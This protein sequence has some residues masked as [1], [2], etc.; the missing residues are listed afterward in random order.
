MALFVIANG[1]LLAFWPAHFLRFYDFWSRG[2]YV[3]KTAP[4]RKN[5][6]KIE[7]RLLG[8]GFLVV[9]IGMFWD[10]VRQLG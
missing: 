7:F 9:G 6:G 8:L 2:D 10:L 5:V 3:G 1:L 4:W